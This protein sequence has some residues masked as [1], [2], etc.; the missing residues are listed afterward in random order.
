MASDTN[1]NLNAVL[2]GLGQG[3]LIFSSDGRLIKD[4]LAARTFLGTTDF[5]M[6]RDEGWIAA[7]TLFNTQQTNPDNM[8]DAVRDR[9]LQSERPIRFHIFHSGEYIPCWATAIQTG[10]DGDVSTM[11][12][13]ENPDWNATSIILDKFRQE[14]RDAISST[15]GHIDIIN[16]TIQH[17]DPQAGVEAL[18]RRIG[19][20][21][22]LI[23][24]HMYRV[25]RLNSML[26][27]LENI[28]T[29][30]IKDV[31][32]ERR[33]KIKLS[34]FLEDFLEELDEINLVDPETD[35]RDHRS[36]IK[37]DVPDN[38]TILA[39]SSYLTRILHDVLRNAIM[40][41]MRGT[42]IKIKA[43]AKDS[44]I[45]VDLSDEGYGVREKERERVFE[46]F[47]RA[48]QPQIIGEFGY[49]LSLYLCKHEVETMNGTMWFDSTENVGTT[50]SFT[51]P[52]WKDDTSSSSSSSDSK[53]SNPPTA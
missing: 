53:K 19:G 16:K 45:Q 36:R 31:I 34:D 43:R 49:G 52:I 1:L 30:R 12:T 37:S 48:R 44:K 35:A 14:M 21:T 11:I 2:D 40:Y 50:F 4:N 27:R 29:G 23:S 6:I 5:S 32:R 25:D 46:E 39:S 28:R 33:H 26:E 22:R 38:L 20:F 3:V 47:K 15:Q 9:A 18:S 8:I 41:S 42:P 10:K 24:V 7:S 13:I 17:H 51:L